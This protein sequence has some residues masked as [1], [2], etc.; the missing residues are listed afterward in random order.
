MCCIRSARFSIVPNLELCI[1]TPLAL[2]SVVL[3]RYTST[4]PFQ[5]P[6]N[7]SED[8][9]K[10]RRS[11]V[12]HEIGVQTNT[13]LMHRLCYSYEVITS[14]RNCN[15]RSRYS[16]DLM[17]QTATRLARFRRWNIWTDGRTDTIFPVI[18]LFT[19]IPQRI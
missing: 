10:L 19:Y 1:R 8:S 7:I 2:S 17:T 5:D 11:T 15:R 12:L 13:N 16:R 6:H 4:P 18:L 3:H 9:R 14:S